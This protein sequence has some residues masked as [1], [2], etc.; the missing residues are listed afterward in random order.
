MKQAIVDLEAHV[1]D[2]AADDAVAVPVSLL[3]AHAGEFRGIPATG[4]TKCVIA[5]V[6]ELVKRCPQDSQVS[7]CLLRAAPNR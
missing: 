3:G 7:P 2:V 1:D 6:R 5:V 4:R